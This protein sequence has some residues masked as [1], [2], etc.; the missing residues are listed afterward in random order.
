MWRQ[1][2]LYTGITIII[3]SVCQ[4]QLMTQILCKHKGISAMALPLPLQSKG[5]AVAGVPLLFFFVSE[6]VNLCKLMVKSAVIFRLAQRSVFK[7][8]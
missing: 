4:V 7:M 3:I 2:W 6:C 1:Q 8:V 5:E